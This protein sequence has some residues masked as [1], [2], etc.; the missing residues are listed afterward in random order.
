M[1]CTA[2]VKSLQACCLEHDGIGKARYDTLWR[3]LKPKS[4]S[5]AGSR[6]VE[7]KSVFPA[8]DTEDNGKGK[9]FQH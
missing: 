8:K 1:L 7:R 4:Y 3:C 2:L 6:P 5:D 9:H